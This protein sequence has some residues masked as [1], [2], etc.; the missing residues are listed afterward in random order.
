MCKAICLPFLQFTNEYWPNYNKNT[1]KEKNL[2]MLK[3]M[4]DWRTKYRMIKIA[5]FRILL[6]FVYC[7]AY[8]KYRHSSICLSDSHTFLVVTHSYVSQATHAFLGMLAHYF[9]NSDI[10]WKAWPILHMLQQW[11]HENLDTF[12]EPTAI[13]FSASCFASPEKLKLIN[14][15]PLEFY[16]WNVK[17]YIQTYSIAILCNLLNTSLTLILIFRL[18]CKQI[19]SWI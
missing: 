3:F 12:F 14:H 10:L 17:C 7:V 13:P 5:A 6:R 16:L 2:K 19:L 8:E 4:D 18:Y 1:I 9:L 11:H 15:N